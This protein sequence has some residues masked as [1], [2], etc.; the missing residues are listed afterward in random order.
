MEV[1]D[2]ESLYELAAE[3]VKGINEQAFYWSCIKSFSTYMTFY[4]APEITLEEL[5]GYTAAVD[6][7]VSANLVGEREFQTFRVAML[8]RGPAF[9]DADKQELVTSDQGQDQDKKYLDTPQVQVFLAAVLGYRCGLRRREVQM[10]WAHDIFPGDQAVLHVRASSLARLKSRSAYRRIPLDA[11]VPADELKVLLDYLERR[12]EQLNKHQALFFSRIDMPQVPLSDQFLFRPITEAFQRI[13]GIDGLPF[14]FHHLRH[15]FANWLLIA[16]LA[17]D[18]SALL[19]S[20]DPLVASGPLDLKRVAAIKNAFFPRMLGAGPAA[21]RKNLYLVSA[22]LGHLSPETSLRHYIHLLDWLAGREVDI[23]LATTLVGSSPKDLGNGCGLSASMPYKPPYDTLLEHPVV[24]MRQY[25]RQYCLSELREVPLG[26]TPPVDLTDIVR[27]IGIAPPPGPSRMMLML[28]RLLQQT[29]EEGWKRG[30]VTADPVV[31]SKL[32]RDHSVSRIVLKA[33]L[34]NY[35]KLYAKQS[36]QVAKSSL[37]MPA[38]P[39]TEVDSVEFW[40]I[41]DAASSAFSSLSKRESMVLAAEFLVERNG[42]RS[43]NVYFGKRW[44]L[45]PSVVEGLIAMGLDPAMLTLD[46]R[47]ADMDAERTH[48]LEGIAQQIGKRGVALETNGLDWE[49]RQSTGATMRLRITPRKDAM[50]DAKLSRMVGRI[51][52]LNYAALWVLFASALVSKC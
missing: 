5:D 4:G 6:A 8:D 29:P 50:S 51:R 35:L 7:T 47:V 34:D 13:R 40:R 46:L 28:G 11:L 32:E 2:W 31:S 15:S 44:A 17:A 37:E 19:D 52:G 39:R 24:F 42:P 21:T 27:G 10:L 38:P 25:V 45:A 16:L 48:E 41:L 20:T 14:R 49:K 30:S 1:E 22:L 12:K 18:N 23:A 33:L 26:Q 3:R 9:L 43:G 36:M